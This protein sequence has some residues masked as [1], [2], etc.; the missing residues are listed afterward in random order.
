MGI[1]STSTL[2]RTCSYTAR[3]M[4]IPPAGASG[5]SRAAMLTPS[6]RMSSPSMTMSPTLMPMRRRRRRASGSL[7]P[8]SPMS[9]WMAIAVLTAATTEGNSMRKPSP[10]VLIKRP[11]PAAVRGSMTAVRN[12]CSRVTTPSSS[13]AIWRL[14][15]T[16]SATRMVVSRR[17]MDVPRRE[18]IS[19]RSNV[20][21]RAG[22]GKLHICRPRRHSGARRSSAAGV[23]SGSLS[24]RDSRWLCRLRSGDVAGEDPAVAPGALG[25]IDGVV[26]RLEQLV[27]AL[28]RLAEGDTD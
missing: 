15:P 7:A 4:Q 11:P 1:R 14:N 26:G 16:I 17:S 24:Q 3:E 2:P 6:P 18:R 9:V 19:R 10:M 12:A 28:R 13:A 23:W 22:G 5:S 8:R 25:G 21:Q 27:D 20:R